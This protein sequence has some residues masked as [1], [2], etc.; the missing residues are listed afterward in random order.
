[1]ICNTT[2]PIYYRERNYNTQERFSISR[3]LRP[4]YLTKALELIEADPAQAWSVGGLAR[5]CGVARRTLQHSFRR[6][7]GVAPVEH[8]RQTRL[9]RARRELLTAAPN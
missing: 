7:V 9:A 8:L 6:F 5:K 4:W 3:H 1:M 2:D